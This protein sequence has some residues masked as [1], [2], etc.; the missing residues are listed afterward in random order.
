MSGR[1]KIHTEIIH[2]HYLV[3]CS[4]TGAMSLFS[5]AEYI[6]FHYL[7][8]RPDEDQ[9]KALHALLLDYGCD[10]R[11]ISNFSEFFVKKISQ[12]GWF[13]NDFP[14]SVARQL[15]MVY[16]T[17]TTHCNLSCAYCYVGDERRDPAFI[18]EFDDAKIII[19]KI[20]NFNPHASVAVTGGEPLTHP[21]IFK[22][23]D[24]LDQSGLKFTLGTNATLIDETCAKKLKAYKNLLFVQASLDGI[25][26]ETHE[27]T[28]GNTFHETMKGIR[29]LIKEKVMFAIA[30]TLHEGNLHEMYD[31][32]CLAYDNGGF[33]APN[34]LRKFPHSLQVQSINLQPASLR[35]C[36]IQTFERTGKEYNTRSRTPECADIDCENLPEMRCKFVCGNGWQTVDLDWNGDVYPCHLL[37]EKEFIIGNILTTEFTEI[38]D[39]SKNSQT[40]VKSYDIPKCKTCPFVS[41]CA[42]GCRASAFYTTGTLAAEDE[43][44]DIL[45]K[46]EVEKLFLKKGI[47]FHFPL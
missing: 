5:S 29:N 7:L 23:L 15:E 34:H 30:P 9:N 8:R 21:D 44:C 46:F 4:E 27:V 43:Y 22:I 1:L 41:T 31:I 2:D 19:N 13:R 26:H 35:K 24:S 36:I 40:R 11:T 32:A 28:R 20:S 18:M 25:T 12:Q 42:G 3:S 16:L 37:R 39:R 38:F 45:Y 10:E 17:I 14:N 6:A 33:F 47:P